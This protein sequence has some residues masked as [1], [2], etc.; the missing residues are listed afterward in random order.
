[1][2][3]NSVI[4]F[5]TNNVENI[6]I[7]GMIFSF[8]LLLGVLRLWAHFEKEKFKSNMSEEDKFIYNTYIKPFADEL[9]DYQHQ[10]SKLRSIK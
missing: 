10:L 4:Q 1:M 6:A 5:I 7:C 8:V 9:K 2:I 3:L